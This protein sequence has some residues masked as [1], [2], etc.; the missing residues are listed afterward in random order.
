VGRLNDTDI[1]ASSIAN[2][3][4][5]SRMHLEDSIETIEKIETELTKKDKYVQTKMF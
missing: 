5:I 3:A 2:P 4:Y 1:K